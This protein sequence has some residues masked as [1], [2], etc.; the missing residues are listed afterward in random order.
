MKSSIKFISSLLALVL[1]FGN[2]ASASPIIDFPTRPIEMLVGF[3]AGGANHI[4]AENLKPEAQRVFEQPMNVVIMPGASGAIAAS[5]LTNAN[6]DGYTVLNATISL[7]ISLHTGIADYKMEDFVGLVMYSDVAPILSIRA[8]LPVNTLEDLIAY[9]KD[10]PNTFTWGHNGL[11]AS[12]HLTGSL[13]FREMGILD[14]VRQVPFTGAS[15]A[16]TQVLGG[17]LDGTVTFPGTIQAQVNAG[18]LRVLG[19]SGTQRVQEF[20]DAPTFLESG[21]DVTLTS[22]RGIFARS[23]TPQ[24]ILDILEAGFAEAVKSEGFRERAIATGEPLVFANSKDFTAIFYEQSIAL[25]TIME[26]LGFVGN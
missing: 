15:E 20:P 6:A 11:G 18:N 3:A 25:R 13:M 10:N 1:V 16:V 26:E 14:Y 23:D 19:V 7:P 2:V 8:D 9:V 22:F 17:H 12:F 21:Y 24:E 4:A 5:F